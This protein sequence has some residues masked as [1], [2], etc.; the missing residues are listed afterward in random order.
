MVFLLFCFEVEIVIVVIVWGVGVCIIVINKIEE[1][2]KIDLI[3]L[4]KMF[5]NKWLVFF[6]CILKFWM[7]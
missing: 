4:K 5:F 7:K 6:I 3:I 2:I 1:L